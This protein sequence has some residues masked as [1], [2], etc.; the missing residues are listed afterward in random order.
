M[1]TPGDSNTT[2]PFVPAEPIDSVAEQMMI[3]L[4]PCFL[5]GTSG[6]H[7]LARIAMLQMIAAYQVVTPRELLLASRIIA[8]GFAAMDSL[9]RSMADPDMPDSLRLRHRAQA[10]ALNRSA[11][12]CQKALDAL[13]Q[14]RTEGEATASPDPALPWTG[15]DLG[16]P[17]ADPELADPRLADPELTNPDL[18][19]P[20][21]EAPMSPPPQRADR[22]AASA[23][24]A[25]NPAAR[26]EGPPNT[27]L[28]QA[29]LG[30]AGRNAKDTSPIRDTPKR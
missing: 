18:A 26:Q 11:E 27:A 4:L 1:A 16:M 25:T 28:L 14:R 24:H 8:F 2:N 9:S 30:A 17:E 23:H 5:D 7:T 20:R 6:D 10:N 15:A 3:F 12:Q 13:L 21:R 22:S 29:L 19:A